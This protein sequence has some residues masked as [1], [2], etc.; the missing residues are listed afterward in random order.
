MKLRLPGT[1]NRMNVE[2][3]T[4]NIERPVLMALR[5]IYFKTSE[6]QNTELQP[7][8]SPSAVSSGPMGSPR[9][10]RGL[11][12]SKVPSRI[13]KAS[14]ALLSHYFILSEYI[15]RCWTF[16]VRCSMFIRF[17]FDQTGRFSSQRRR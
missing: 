16:N 8:T 17:F 11:S 1:V 12:L 15:I 4:S 6:P 5:F 14:F 7:A 2:H 9:R 10:A 3:R 13:L